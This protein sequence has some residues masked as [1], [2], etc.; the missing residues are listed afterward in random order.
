MR[1]LTICIWTEWHGASIAFPLLLATLL[2]TDQ[3][4]WDL[5][6]MLSRSSGNGSQMCE[7]GYQH[8]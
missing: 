8:L 7:C 1:L 2:G 6:A 5:A 4:S 3:A